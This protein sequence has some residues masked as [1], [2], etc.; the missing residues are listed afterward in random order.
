MSVIEYITLGHGMAVVGGDLTA[1][2]Q[3]HCNEIVKSFANN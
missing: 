2:E 3:K 1:R